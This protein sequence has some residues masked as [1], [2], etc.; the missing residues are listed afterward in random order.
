MEITVKEFQEHSF[1]FGSSKNF[2]KAIA[3]YQWIEGKKG[4]WLLYQKKGIKVVAH[5]KIDNV[6]HNPAEVSIEYA[7]NLLMSR[8][9]LKDPHSPENGY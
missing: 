2:V 6:V 4:T 8:E 5:L 9:F 3:I 7:K 1:T